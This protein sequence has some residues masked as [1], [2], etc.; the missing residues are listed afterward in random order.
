M[1]FKKSKKEKNERKKIFFLDLKK[2]KN[3][4]NDVIKMLYI[5]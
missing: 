2:H 1:V 4:D 3:E 5:T